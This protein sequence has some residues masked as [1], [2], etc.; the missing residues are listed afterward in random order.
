MIRKIIGT[1]IVCFTMIFWYTH[2][3]TRILLSDKELRMDH[4]LI[5][6]ARVDKIEH[7][8]IQANTGTTLSFPEP[9]MFYNFQVEKT[10]KWD[11]EI[12]KITIAE[13][14]FSSCSSSYRSWT[15]YLLYLNPSKANENQYYSYRSKVR[16][17]GE[18]IRPEFNPLREKQWYKQYTIITTAWFR[19]RRNT[20]I[21]LENK[22]YELQSQIDYYKV[23]YGIY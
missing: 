12:K 9:D 18:N 23:K 2:A 20:N 16:D 5:V 21:F 4:E 6:T 15:T 11:Q 8:P 1:S 17:Y 22:R 13:E 19:L 7:V 3:C 14:S 10:F